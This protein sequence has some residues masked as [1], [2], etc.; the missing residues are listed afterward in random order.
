M[1]SIRLFLVSVILSAIILTSF[2]AAF[3]GYQQGMSAANELRDAQLLE[4]NQLI[5]A[6]VENKYTSL[7]TLFPK[8]FIYQVFD[9]NKLLLSSRNKMAPMTDNLQSGFHSVSYENY[10]WRI[11]ITHNNTQ[12]IVSGVRADRF[13]FLVENIILKAIK[14]LLLIIPFLALIIWLIVF[15]GL[16][17]L[18]KL[19]QELA[20]RHD[21][22]LSTISPDGYPKE[23]TQLLISSNQLFQRL[24]TAFI[25]ERRFSAD[26]AHELRTPLTTL[27]LAAHNLT[28]NPQDQQA[29]HSLNTNVERMHQ[30]VEQIL[31]LSKLGVEQY[32]NP[33]TL[34]VYGLLQTL[35]VTYYPRIEAKRQTIE[36]DGDPCVIVGFPFAIELMLGNLL[37][38]A[39]KY[40]PAQGDLL[41][42]VQ[43]QL[44][45]II[46]TIDDS[47]VGIDPSLYDRVF[48]RFYR[49]DGDR[50]KSGEQGSGLGMALV[51]EVVQLHN[52][53]V[54]LSPSI[55]G[56]LRVIVT[57]PIKFSKE[58]P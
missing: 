6:L 26:A 15:I 53:A 5:T 29:I 25:R 11:L 36:L 12:I 10:N 21:A 33:Q 37:D 14:P 9:H 17:P 2:V 31:S 55:L 51:A 44:D 50:H 38:N 27:K 39:S 41:I 49:V 47:G 4:Y 19:A 40:T 35:I 16:K 57:L 46:I 54:Q 20:V 8:R 23:L 52:G 43:T 24:D 45:T 7:H 48:D 22:D 32:Q 1:N 13:S 18:K 3:D 30:S 58:I 42:Q 28:E 34:D 56:G